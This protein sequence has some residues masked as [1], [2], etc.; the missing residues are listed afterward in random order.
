MLHA[1]YALFH[2]GHSE[3]IDSR[4]IIIDTVSVSYVDG[5]GDNFGSS[6]AKKNGFK[7]KNQSWADFDIVS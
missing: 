6:K 5:C 3:A 2:N 4:S 1:K 7:L